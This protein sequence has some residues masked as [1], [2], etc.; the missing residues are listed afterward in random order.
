LWSGIVGNPGAERIE[1]QSLPL[2]SRLQTSRGGTGRIGRPIV[3]D[4][5]GLVV[6]AGRRT[7]PVVPSV[8]FL[9]WRID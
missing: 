4:D 9:G 6:K 3:D 7:E 2:R 5:V 1:F 8:I